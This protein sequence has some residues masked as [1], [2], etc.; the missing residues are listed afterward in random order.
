M[1]LT[2][3][4]VCVIRFIFLLSL[5]RFPSRERLLVSPRTV[6]GRNH[7]DA[8]M[9]EKAPDAIALLKADHRTVEA[10]FTKFEGATPAKQQAIAFEICTELVIHTTIEEELFYPA[11]KDKIDADLLDEAYVEHDGAKMLIAQIANGKVGD[12][13]Y[14]A[15]VSV[16]SEEIEH[17]VH[18]EEMPKEGMFAQARATDVDLQALGEAMAARK[19]ELKIRFKA[20]G[21]P[22]P[23]MRTVKA[24]EVVLGEPV[25]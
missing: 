21:L 6:A 4:V 11:L 9:A 7:E 20:E 2:L 19:E 5:V 23:T 18:E 8:H 10:L 24:A 25:A 12:D 15:K 13:F 17:H 3:I 16:L 22:P 14:E 1:H